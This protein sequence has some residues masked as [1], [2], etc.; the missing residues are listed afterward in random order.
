MTTRKR[1][2]YNMLI[3]LV[4]LKVVEILLLLGLV[5]GLVAFIYHVVY[6]LTTRLRSLL[7]LIEGNVTIIDVQK[8]TF[9]QVV[10]EAKEQAKVAAEE[11][12][13]TVETIPAK[14]V[15]K[16]HEAGDSPST[17]LKKPGGST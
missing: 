11:V 4:I 8:A 2:G 7:T 16:I 12:K 3:T 13:K 1:T 17:I 14:V 5:V 6:P 15:E 9:I 10:R